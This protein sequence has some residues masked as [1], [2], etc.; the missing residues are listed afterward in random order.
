MNTNPDV[1]IDHVDYYV[2]QTLTIIKTTEEI[3]EEAEQVEKEKAQD[4]QKL[5]EDEDELKN[6][7][8]NDKGMKK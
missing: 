6:M 7:K 1:K 4:L 3:A 5:T 8:Q 2:V